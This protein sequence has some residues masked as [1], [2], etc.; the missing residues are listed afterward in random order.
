MI[1]RGR[2]TKTGVLLSWVTLAVSSTALAAG[3][4]T[5]T[6]CGS[7]GCA[8]LPT[9]TL[10]GLLTLPDALKPADPPR[11][12]PYVLFRVADLGDAAHEVVYISRD[13]HALLGFPDGK[14][15]RIVPADDA[16]LLQDAVSDRTPYPAPAA[17]AP[18]GG[19]FE[20]GEAG[21]ST[22]RWPAVAIL[23]VAAATAIA[24]YGLARRS[25]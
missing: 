13:D 22:G 7:N 12:Q 16:K 6:A 25:R 3:L 2:S 1:R 24:A 17:D 4:P 5:P 19:L 20:S 11:A 9:A 8:R 21:R 23:A 10:Q 15:W 18:L 14:G